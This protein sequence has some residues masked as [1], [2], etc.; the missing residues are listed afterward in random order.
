MGIR[1]KCSFEPFI[2]LPF[3]ELSG[4]AFCSRASFVVEDTLPPSNVSKPYI[5]SKVA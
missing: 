5:L 1:S 2:S 3:D 4:S